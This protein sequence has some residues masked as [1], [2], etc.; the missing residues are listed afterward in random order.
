[1]S[2]F[3]TLTQMASDTAISSST[4]P[5]DTMNSPGIENSSK[6]ICSSH[7]GKEPCN[8]DK[9]CNWDKKMGKCYLNENLAS[10][11]VTK[12]FMTNSEKNKALNKIQELKSEAR[13]IK[14]KFDGMINK[15]KV[16]NEKTELVKPRTTRKVVRKKKEDAKARKEGRRHLY[17]ISQQIQNLQD[18][19][20]FMAIVIEEIEHLVKKLAEN[21]EIKENDEIVIEI[22]E[23]IKALM[24]T[25]KVL[26]V[27]VSSMSSYFASGLLDK[28]IY[29]LTATGGLLKVLGNGFETILGM[30]GSKALDTLRA[31]MKRLH[32]N[33][34]KEQDR[35]KKEKALRK[36]M[37]RKRS[38]RGRQT[39]KR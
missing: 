4:R 2:I 21:N 25:L 9:K 8:F 32:D 3:S 16:H 15:L 17:N 28:S 24:E 27:N 39:R 33:W 31:Q 12:L 10:M 35:L 36:S 29:I 19:V 7:I 37:R 20:D 6:K 14:S 22:E 1:M 11:R 18:A 13:D 23:N 5:S 30:I 38:R 26:L 34:R